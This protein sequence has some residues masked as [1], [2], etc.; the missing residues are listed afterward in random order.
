[1]LA[2]LR[3]LFERTLR[4][5]V[6]LMVLAIWGLPLAVVAGWSLLERDIGGSLRA[7][8]ATTAAEV[9]AALS[10]GGSPRELEDRLDAIA[11]RHT[12][13]VRVLR[14]S[15]RTALDVDR[16]DGDDVVH[17]IGTLFF[18]ADGAPTL[19]ELDASL[20]PVL[21]RPEV[22]AARL[23]DAPLPVTGCRSAPSGKLLV[24]HAAEASWLEGEP[25]VVY[26][27]ESSRRAARALYDLRYHLARLSVAMLPIALVFSWWMGRR[28]VAPIETLRARV[29]DKAH[30]ANVR[31]DL[32][33][34]RA[35]E[36]ADLAEAFNHLLASVAA[37]KDEHQA[38]VADLAHEIKNPAAAIR[39]C[40]ESLSSGDADPARVARIARILEASSSR[41]DHLVSQFLDLARAEAG[42]RGE[43]R[44]P[45][46]LAAVAR[47]VATA[48]TTTVPV[49]VTAEE[50]IVLAAPGRIES[51]VRNLLD[52][53]VSYAALGPTPAVRVAVARRG[54]VVTLDVVDTGPGIARADLPH[55]FD[56]FFTT[57]ACAGEGAAALT[58]G[59]GLGLALVKAVVEA[60]G[61]TIEACSPEGSGAVFHVELPAARLPHPIHTPSVE[62]SR[63]VQETATSP[64]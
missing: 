2:T 9:H 61:G 22:D 10:E 47:G 16:D 14:P 45:V 41:L 64:S 18:G 37:K 32:A 28:M 36:I 29:L 25:V 50:A 33:P 60:H 55:V 21:E 35:G 63:V 51:V 20:P 6:V 40:A 42:L 1:M 53:A 13:R 12:A 4:V 46:D 24:C 48:E 5:N 23:S 39:A 34:A 59:T 49:D 7:S 19:R 44:V 43:E 11:F 15:G 31:A 3:A 17:R 62:Q 57:R 27:Q 52:N 58:G 8:A 38:F 56:R 54:A 26:V 30:E